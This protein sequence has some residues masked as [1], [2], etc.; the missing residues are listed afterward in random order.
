M[1]PF[2]RTAAS[3]IRKLVC[4]PLGELGFDYVIRFRGNIHVSDTNG[5]HQAGGRIGCGQERTRPQAARDARVTAKGQQV[6]AVVLRACQSAWKEPWCLATS[7]K[8]A[9]A[10]ALIQSLRPAL[11]YRATVPRHQ[12]ICSSGWGYHST[13]VG[14]PTRSRD[15]LLMI[16]AF[17]TALLTL[18]GA[19]WRKSRHGPLIEV[20]HEQN[21][22]SFAVPP[23]LHALRPHPQYARAQALASFMQKFNHA[24]SRRHS[25][26]SR[27]LNLPSR[28]EGDE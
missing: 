15:R 6:G 11:D 2:W 5:Q 18:L 14:E 12:V 28:N 24:V 8:D 22:D 26:L 16:S 25:A 7:Q 19:G 17:A 10:A 4:L 27:Y 1:S 3:A 20:Q 23:R 13:R 9:T 21:A